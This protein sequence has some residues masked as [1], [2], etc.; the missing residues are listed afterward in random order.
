MR[1]DFDPEASGASLAA[2]EAAI[3]IHYPV[4]E[5]TTA[6]LAAMIVNDKVALVDLRSADEQAVSMI[7]TAIAIDEAT[8]PDRLR[9]L[10]D[11]RGRGLGDRSIVVYCAVGLRSARFVAQWPGPRSLVLNLRGGIF[12]WFLDG[13]PLGDDR[14]RV[15]PFDARWGR[16]LGADQ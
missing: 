9:D 8:R 16:L 5:V 1:F 11:G 10:I 12:R 3:A 6:T 13:R 7:P 15:H 4:P 2:C 14:R